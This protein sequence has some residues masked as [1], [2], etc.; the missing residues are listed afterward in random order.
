M[1]DLFFV[2]VTL[3]TIAVTMV[4]AGYTHVK[5]S[6]GFDESNLHNNESAIALA[7]FDTAYVIYDNVF[8]FFIIGF[9]IM[10][11][12]SAWFIPSH[13]IFLFINIVGILVMIFLGAVLSNLYGEIIAEDEIS[14][15]ANTWFTKTSFAMTKLPFLGAIMIFLS[16]IVMYSKGKQEGTYG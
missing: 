16:T 6:E 15:V 8:F 14:D 10:L 13:P 7:Q 9:I 1:R 5:I 2:M 12:I 4:I 11:L 3:F